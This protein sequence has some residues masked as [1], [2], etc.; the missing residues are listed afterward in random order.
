M[1]GCWKRKTLQGSREARKGLKE[2]KSL[3][4]GARVRRDRGPKGE[5]ETVER[6]CFSFLLAGIWRAS[7]D[8]EITVTSGRERESGA[9]ISFRCLT[10]SRRLKKHT[11]LW[12]RFLREV[13]REWVSRRAVYSRMILSLKGLGAI[14]HII[15]IRID[16]FPSHLNAVISSP[17]MVMLFVCFTDFYNTDKR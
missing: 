3:V 16:L 2:E 9:V 17:Y 4:A 8:T 14:S 13:S 11:R 12:F 6:K 5:K 7:R 15:E 1:D 10:S